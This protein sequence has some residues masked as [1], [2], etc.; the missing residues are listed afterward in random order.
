MI[1]LMLGAAALVAAIAWWASPPT[2]SASASAFP[3]RPAPDAATQWPVDEKAEP[4]ARVAS[5]LENVDDGLSNRE[6]WQHISDPAKSN[7]PR[8]LFAELTQLGVDVVRADA[9]GVDRDRFPDYWAEYPSGRADPCCTAIDVHAAGAYRLST[10]RGLVRA[11]V[12][13]TAVESRSRGP[14]V[15]TTHVLLRNVASGWIPTRHERA[16]LR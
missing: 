1:P 13:W 11:S 10:N 12:L 2:V 3:A 7:L 9:T 5:P 6:L 14:L 15:R 4:G 8:E 16:E